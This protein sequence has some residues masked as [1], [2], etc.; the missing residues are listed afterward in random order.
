MPK[1]QKKALNQMLGFWINEIMWIVL[2]CLIHQPNNFIVLHLKVPNFGWWKTWN[3]NDLLKSFSSIPCL[4][5]GFLPI[6][7]PLFVSRSFFLRILRKNVLENSFKHQKF[8][9]LIVLY[10]RKNLGSWTEHFLNNAKKSAW[11]YMQL[12]KID[13]RTGH[14]PNSKA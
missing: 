8:G 13:L 1:V 10:F 11:F 14:Q 9:C 4:V 2:N 3:H 12:S 6:V 5:T 7:R